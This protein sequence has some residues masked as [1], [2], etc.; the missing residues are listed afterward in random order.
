L[1]VE[2]ATSHSVARRQPNT[3]GETWIQAFPNREM[4]GRIIADAAAREKISSL[5]SYKP[6]SPPEA[7]NVKPGWIAPGADW[8]EDDSSG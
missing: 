4:R 7:R 3:T 6:P 5:R 8:T 1:H 2:P